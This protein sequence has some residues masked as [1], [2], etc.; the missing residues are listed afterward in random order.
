MPLD[1]IRLTRDQFMQ[2]ARKREMLLNGVDADMPLGE[3]QIPDNLRLK[4]GDTEEVRQKKKKKLKALKYSH[5]VK[6]QE[7]ESKSR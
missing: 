4:K 1:Y 3:F 6:M 5:K 2:N 7:L